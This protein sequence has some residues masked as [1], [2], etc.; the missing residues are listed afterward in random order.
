MLQ[1]LPESAQLDQLW[2]PQPPLVALMSTQILLPPVLLMCKSEQV[3]EEG[4]GMKEARLQHQGESKNL[5]H[6]SRLLAAVVLA[7]NQSSNN[8][9]CKQKNRVLVL[10]VLQEEG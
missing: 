10:L 2:I 4:E 6:Q 5:L 1:T 3:L 8:R 7:Q 9:L